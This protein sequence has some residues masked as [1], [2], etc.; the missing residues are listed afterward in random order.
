[1]SSY[2]KKYTSNKNDNHHLF[3]TWES[4]YKNLKVYYEGEVIHTET[5]PGRF[6]KGV[7]FEHPVLQ[8]V[9]LKFSSESPIVMQ[10]KANGVKYFPE[11]NIQKMKENTL[12][13]LAHL[14]TILAFLS[15]IGAFIVQLTFGFNL[16][17]P[18]ALIQLVFDIVVVAIYITSAVLLYKNKPW[19][20]FLGSITFVCMTLL[21]LLAVWVSGFGLANLINMVIRVAIIVYI[22]RH[23]NDVMALMRTKETENPDLLDNSSSIDFEI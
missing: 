15:V 3:L 1:M 14:F 19:A 6:M 17:I 20:Y 4:G 22:V 5:S 16:N 23:F 10:V 8:S 12:G 7:T 2:S 18:E 11:N 13:G 9:Q 21:T